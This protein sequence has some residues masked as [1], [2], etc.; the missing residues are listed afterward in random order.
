LTV[1]DN[2]GATGTDD[3][4][5]TVNDAPGNTSPVAVA[6][7]DQTIT[8]PLNVATVDGSASSDPDGTIASYLWIKAAGPSTYTITSPTTA[9]TNIT[10][11][12]QGTYV[13][14]LTVTDDDGA[15]HSDDITIQ[16][17]PE[18]VIPPSNRRRFFRGSWWRNIFRRG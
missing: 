17:D 4:Q 14:R 16:V 13:F 15:L 5:I 3:V 1:T 8:L 12:I 6:G 7:S 10:G 9:I 11:L 2:D 18:P